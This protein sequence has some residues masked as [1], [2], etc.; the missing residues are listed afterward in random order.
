[1][2]A[3]SRG[4]PKGASTK[5]WSEALTIASTDTD[6]DGKVR[7]RLLAEKTWEMALAGDMAAIREIGDRLDGK[8]AQSMDVTHN[9]SDVFLQML[10]AISNGRLA[11]RLVEKPGQSAPVRH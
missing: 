6:K 10:E 8:A 1:M 4:R 11:D 9:P 2:P 7:L 5:P 3:A